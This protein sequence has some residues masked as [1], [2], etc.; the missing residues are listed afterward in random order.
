MRV[1]SVYNEVNGKREWFADVT[2]VSQDRYGQGPFVFGE[3][4]EDGSLDRVIESLH[5]IRNS[6]PEEYRTK[7]RC[8]ISSEGGYEDS[9]SASITVK[10]YRPET[11]GE[12]AAR[13]AEMANE[14]A[15]K[16][17]QEKSAYE[18]LKRKYG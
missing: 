8:E 13:E 2:V 9:H 18:A 3:S 16:E 10:Y 4:Y 15:A 1:R 6:I 17:A 7:A 14:T 5:K 11:P 12:T